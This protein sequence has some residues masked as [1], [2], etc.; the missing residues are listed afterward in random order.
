MAK[1]SLTHFYAKCFECEKECAARNAQAWAHQHANRTGH[2][3][4][5]QLAWR[6]ARETP[7]G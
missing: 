7:D 6:V 5:L 1:Q 4:E 2:A 3:V